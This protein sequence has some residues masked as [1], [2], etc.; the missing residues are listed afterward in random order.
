MLIPRES[1][2]FSSVLLT[3]KVK[4][5]HPGSWGR[6]RCDPEEYFENSNLGILL[7]IVEY[8][9]NRNAGI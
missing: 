4:I 5:A 6:S 7:S 8:S 2:G 9:D 1:F 3:G